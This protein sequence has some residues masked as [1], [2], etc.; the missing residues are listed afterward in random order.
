MIRFGLLGCGRIAKRHSDLLGGNHI[1]GAKL[2]AVCDNSEQRLKELASL[3]SAGERQVSPMQ[4]AAL[5]L[6]Q[7]TA[8]Y[9]RS[10][11]TRKQKRQSG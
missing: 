5:I 8:S 1:E 2:V 6:E 3:L 4:V 9:F 11:A 10:A 7:A